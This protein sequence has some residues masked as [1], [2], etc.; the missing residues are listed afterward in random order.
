MF[1]DTN[2]IFKKQKLVFI[3][4]FI[5][6]FCSITAFAEFKAEYGQYQGNIKNRLKIG[7]SNCVSKELDSEGNCYGLSVVWLYSKWL[8]FAHPENGD[9]FKST[10]TDILGEWSDCENIK[11][12]ALLVEYFHSNQNKVSQNKTL[13]EQKINELVKPYNE[14]MREEYS[15]VLP[16]NDQLGKLLQ[17]IVICEHRLIIIHAQNHATALFKDGNDYYYY[18]P[19]RRAGEIKSTDIH[20]IGRLIFQGHDFDSSNSQVA[21]LQIFSLDKNKQIYPDR[22][23]ILQGNDI[24]SVDKDGHDNAESLSLV[25]SNNCLELLRYFTDKKININ[26]PNKNGNTA[27][28]KAIGNGNI[29]IVKLLLEHHANAD[30]IGSAGYTALIL[31]TYYNNVEIVKL[32]LEHNA[33]VDLATNSGFTALGMAELYNYIEIAELIKSYKN[34]KIVTADTILPTHDKV[35]VSYAQKNHES[36]IKTSHKS[37][38]K[39]SHESKSKSKSKTSHKNKK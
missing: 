37:K 12:F 17:E 23:K 32:L 27:L 26:L 22:Q 9:W 3:L 39:A 14:E 20:Y 2:K 31:A 24:L 35:S 34:K 38:N 11:K 33:N 18:D 1:F 5:S 13:L 4:L 29:E 10:I 30:A 28:K 25:V 8:Q 19:N 16:L 21:L 36:K 7:Q 15:I 6:L